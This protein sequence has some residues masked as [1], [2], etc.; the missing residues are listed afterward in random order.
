M[1][2]DPSLVGSLVHFFADNIKITAAKFPV[3]VDK[4]M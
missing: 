2:A 3:C 1:E 4:A